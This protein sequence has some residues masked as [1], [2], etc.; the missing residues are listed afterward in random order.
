MS[1]DFINIMIGIVIG[2]IIGYYITIIGVAIEISKKLTCEETEK[3]II[4]T[5]QWEELKEESE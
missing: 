4:Y 3:T 5:Y 2:I 1:D